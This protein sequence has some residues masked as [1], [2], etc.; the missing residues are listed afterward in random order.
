MIINLFPVRVLV[1]DNDFDIEVHQQLI[2]ICK[3]YKKWKER[4]ESAA[5]AKSLI[6][7]DRDKSQYS[8]FFHQ[9][10]QAKQINGLVLKLGNEYLKEIGTVPDIYQIFIQKSWPTFIQSGGSISLHTHRNA[11][12]SAVYYLDVDAKSDKINFS[13]DSKHEE[14]LMPLRTNGASD[15]EMEVKNGRLIIFPSHLKHYVIQSY[16]KEVRISIAYDLTVTLKP[17]NLKK[18]DGEMQMSHPSCWHSE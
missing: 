7:G 14:E 3:R 8:S 12:L 2:K 5:N 1:K 13:R 17:S 18:H 4:S 11:C 9:L 16:S 15:F 10:P 6:T